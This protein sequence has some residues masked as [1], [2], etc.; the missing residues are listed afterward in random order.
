VDRVLKNEG[1]AGGG[2][3]NVRARGVVKDGPIS[4]NALIGAVKFHG[5]A[6]ERSNTLNSAVG[7]TGHGQMIALAITVCQSPGIDMDTAKA[8]VLS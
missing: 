8:V 3:R 1:D 6:P 2:E 7:R 5:S 4:W